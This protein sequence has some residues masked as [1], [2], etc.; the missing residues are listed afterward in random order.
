LAQLGLQAA[1][2]HLD[3]V[4]S[5][6]TDAELRDAQQQVD[7]AQAALDKAG[8]PPLDTPSA[9]GTAPAAPTGQ[10]ASS[11]PAIDQMQLQHT[12]QQ[13]QQQTQSLQQQIEASQ[14]RA[15]FDGTIE[16]VQVRPGDA[17]D[18]GR[19]VLVIASGGPPLVTVD[20]TDTDSR[21]AIGNAV[22][23]QGDS[24]ATSSKGTIVALQDSASGSGKQAQ[25]QVDWSD[26][27][28]PL[29]ATVQLKLILDTKDGVLL[30]PAQA[31]HTSGTRRTVEILDGADRRTVDV[32][33]G[34]TSADQV[35]IVSGLG[36][37]QQVILPS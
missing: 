31:I 37:G 14:M 3:E 36:E 2:T 22:D 28:P 30:V 26:A 13:L 4:N 35:E 15:P 23:I 21:V 16:S 1:Q 20:A 10:D 19:T 7:A 11:S 29:G 6:P 8:L 5:H 9:P 27:A 24:A 17:V 32:Q 25:V 33:T 18:P 12:Q 34:V